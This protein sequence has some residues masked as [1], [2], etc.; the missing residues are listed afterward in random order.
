MRLGVRVHDDVHRSERAEPRSD[1]RSRE[2]VAKTFAR[3]TDC[4]VRI[5]PTTA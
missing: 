3:T 4:H 2:G 1:A 5:E